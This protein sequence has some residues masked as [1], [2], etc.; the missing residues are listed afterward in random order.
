[1]GFMHE[2][3]FQMKPHINNTFK[4][5]IDN[6]Y[7]DVTDLRQ[8]SCLNDI[9]TLKPEVKREKLYMYLEIT[10]TKICN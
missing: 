1:M 2:A 7:N 3:M 4:Q 5:H 6:L 9:M 8:K 10:I